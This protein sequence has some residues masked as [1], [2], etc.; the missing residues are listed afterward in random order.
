M[1]PGRRIWT[2]WM[3]GAAKIASDLSVQKLTLKVAELG[4]I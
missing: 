3:P 2:D 1:A 4:L